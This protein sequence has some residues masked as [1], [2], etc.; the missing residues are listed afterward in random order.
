MN[1]KADDKTLEKI[2][3]AKEELGK[4]LLL[5][6]HFY[7]HDDIVRFADFIGDSLV[8][9]QKAAAD[10]QARYIVFCS[11]AFM[12][13]MARILCQPQQEV[14]HPEPLARCPLADMASLAEVEKAW[15]VLEGIGKKIIPVV[16]V[17]SNAD[18]KAFCAKN[19][20][21]V[22]TSANAKKVFSHVFEKNASLFF[23]PDENMGRNISGDLGIKSD[24]MCLWNPLD[25]PE[26]AGTLSRAK[27]FIWKGFCEVHT[28]MGTE[29]IGELKR[30]HPGIN[31]IVHPECTPEVYQAANFAGSTSF[32][33]RTIESAEAG[34]QWAVGTEW[35][36]V[37][38][39]KTEN[40]DKVIIHLKESWCR[41][42]ADVTPEKLADVLEGI[43]DGRYTGRVTVDVEIARYAKI[44]LERMLEIS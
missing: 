22:C 36:F 33:K 4:D 1:K 8:L 29:S 30:K 20:G 6:A 32:I 27:V 15:S 12:A 41:D 26:D 37:N 25:P 5:L 40:P 10:R 31:I 28:V 24:E 13:E 18:L 21:M 34:S 17:N 39:L 11:V 35:N 3:R 43:V 19:E 44:A 7:Q 9:A 2:Q 16:Y 23:F 38:R 42:M 14:F